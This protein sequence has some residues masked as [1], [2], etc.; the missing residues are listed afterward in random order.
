M[1][2]NVSKTVLK[3]WGFSMIVREKYI[4]NDDL[5][6]EALQYAILSR[7]YTS[8]RHDF[9]SGGLNNKQQKMLEGKLGEKAVKLFLQDNKVSFTEDSTNYD[10][11]DEYDFLLHNPNTSEKDL[12]IDVKTRTK[13]FHTRTLEMCEQAESHPKDIYISTRLLEDGKTVIL[14]GWITYGDLTEK[15]K[16]E[17]NGYLDNYAIYDKDLRPMKDLKDILTD[18]QN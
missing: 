3:D 4:I 7:S 5:Y 12:K 2:Q 17:N 16:I 10:E 8:N 11:R 15:G 13:E 6:E 9:H 18:F 14:L 1:L